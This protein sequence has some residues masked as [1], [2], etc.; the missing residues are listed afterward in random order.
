M[1]SCLQT[2]NRVGVCFSCDML[3]FNVSTDVHCSAVMS[4]YLRLKLI[5]SAL[6]VVSYRHA[7]VEDSKCRI[8][9]NIFTWNSMNAA[10]DYPRC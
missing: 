2:G 6:K 8:M 1:S 9:C 3:M 4:C 7:D 5:L 10:A